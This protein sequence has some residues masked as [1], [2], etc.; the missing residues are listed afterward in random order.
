[1][2]FPIGTKYTDRKGRECVIVDIYTTT[3]H[4][5]QVVKVRYVAAH[6]LMGQSVLDHDVCETTIRRA[7]DAH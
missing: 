6:K 2:K 7:I 4:A 1:M 5:G 3:N